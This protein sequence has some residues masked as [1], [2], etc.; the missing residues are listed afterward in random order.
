MNEIDVGI[1]V[2]TLGTRP[3]YLEKTLKSIRKAGRAHIS[4][5]CPR[6]VDLNRFES[7]ALIDSRIDDPGLGLPEAINAGIRRLPPVVRFVNWL[8][9]DDLLEPGQ[10]NKLA[11][12]LRTGKY[13]F[14]WGRCRYID[15]RGRE[16]WINKSGR[17]ASVLIRLG[18]NL[19]PQPGA[20]FS[21]EVFDE[22]GGLN[23]SYGWAFDQDLFTKFIRKFQVLFLPEVVSSFR[24]HAGSLSAG[25]REGSVRESSEIRIVNMPAMLRP[26][27]RVL[28]IPIRKIIKAAGTRM[29]TLSLRD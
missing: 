16:I 22:V 24:W 8:G 9:D 13:Q 6:D 5:V 21:R 28:E 14:I 19:I 7:E 2:P 4:I 3:E 15:E 23:P 29:N 27:G 10:L 26:I 25:S 20:L 1:V 17:W 12:I 18:P 11:S